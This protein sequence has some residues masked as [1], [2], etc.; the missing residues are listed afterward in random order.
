MTQLTPA[1]AHI[2]SVDH[3]TFVLSGNPLYADL[4]AENARLS[5][6]NR[7]LTKDNGL[8]Q[9]LVESKK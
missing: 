6:E 4:L 3:A 9:A 5:D 1:L 7:D 8:L 2:R